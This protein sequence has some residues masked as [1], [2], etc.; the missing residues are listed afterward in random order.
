MSRFIAK[1]LC[2]CVIIC[3][4]LPDVPSNAVANAATNL[5]AP[6]SHCGEQC[7]PTFRTRDMSAVRRASESVHVIRTIPYFL[8]RHNEFGLFT[9]LG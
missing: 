6:K 9:I 8:V 5:C 4:L 3:H 7:A 1:C 2:K